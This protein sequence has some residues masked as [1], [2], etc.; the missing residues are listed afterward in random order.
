MLGKAPATLTPCMLT[1]T[2]FPAMLKQA[3]AAAL[4]ACAAGF[5]VYTHTYKLTLE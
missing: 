2:V 5:P 1:V 3:R 4:Q